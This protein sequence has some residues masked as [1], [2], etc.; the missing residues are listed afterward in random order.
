MICIVH[1][2]LEASANASGSISALNDAGFSS[3]MMTST[4]SKKKGR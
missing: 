1:L 2:V 4:S 3:L